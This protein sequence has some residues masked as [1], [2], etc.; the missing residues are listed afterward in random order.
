MKLLTITEAAQLLGLS[1]S[2]LYKKT[3]AKSIAFV[4]L[5]LRVLFDEAAIKR[6]ACRH[7]VQPIGFP[8]D[9]FTTEEGNDAA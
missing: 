3:S 1:R 5:G 4:K 2:T 7:A 9:F 8:Q 6:W